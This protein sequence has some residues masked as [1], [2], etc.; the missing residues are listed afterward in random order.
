[1]HNEPPGPSRQGPSFVYFEAVD[2]YIV[3]KYYFYIS[4]SL[5]TLALNIAYRMAMNH[6]CV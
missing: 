4:P 1:M 6:L 5:T 3:I 2:V